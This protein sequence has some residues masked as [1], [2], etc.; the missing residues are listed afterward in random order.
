MTM[1]D[2]YYQFGLDINTQEFLGHAVANWN[3][4]NYKEMPAIHTM[5]KMKLYH[6][7]ISRYEPFLSPY[8]YPKWGLGELP[9]AFSRLSA[10]WG[11]TYAL[12]QVIKGFKYGPDKKVTGVVGENNTAKCKY[13]VCSPEYCSG[14]EA[15][16]IDQKGKILRAIC[17]IDHPLT[18]TDNTDSCQIVFP[19]RQLNRKYDIYMSVINHTYKVC[20][21]GMYVAT[22]S[23][24]I[25]TETP[26]KELEACFKLLHPIIDRFVWTEPLYQVSASDGSDNI[27]CAN[28]YDASMNFETV[29]SDVWR[30]Y[31]G[32][33][34][35]L[36]DLTK[37]IT[38]P[39]PDE[40]KKM[41]QALSNQ[42]K[43]PSEE[44]STE[45]PSSTTT[46]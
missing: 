21:K 41:N 26:A 12:R 14:P 6:N 10:I 13:V 22:I 17:L 28:S 32:I 3:S 20:P 44:S 8:I 15:K 39:T 35:K 33:T 18:G 43:Q 38:P 24:T 42:S 16:R 31:K 2:L 5:R 29:L 7:S 37:K 45:D 11:G 25:E 34:G 46:S 30:I 23:T 27:F 1:K 4:E 9:Q 19:A 36:P 40:L